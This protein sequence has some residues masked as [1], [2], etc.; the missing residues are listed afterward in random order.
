MLSQRKAMGTQAHNKTITIR[1]NAS[2]I[3]C[4]LLAPYAWPQMGSIPI[5]NPARTEYPVMFAKPMERDP[6]ASSSSPRWPRNNMDIMARAYN[7]NPMIII[8]PPILLICF[9]SS[10]T[11]IWNQIVSQEVSNLQYKTLKFQFTLC[12]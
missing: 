9:S 4:H 3:R 6:L 12:I 11:Y 2:P 1:C 10:K 5:A 7:N 8:G